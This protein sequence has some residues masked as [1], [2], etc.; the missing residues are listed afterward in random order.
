[1]CVE[2]TVR[3]RG[4]RGDK[5]LGSCSGCLDVLRADLEH[6][7]KAGTYIG[8]LS[9]QHN[10]NLVKA[11]SDLSVLILLYLT[12]IVIMFSFLVCLRA[13]R[14]RVLRMSERL[15]RGNALV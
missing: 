10:N 3:F 15:Q 4:Y 2:S 5:V 1:L 8:Q 11:I 7:L 14:L 12:Y 13:S 6:L 9:L